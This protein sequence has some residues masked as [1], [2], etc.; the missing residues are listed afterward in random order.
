MVQVIDSADAGKEISYASTP[1]SEDQGYEA[2]S[3]TKEDIFQNP[4]D[5]PNTDDANKI[6]DEECTHCEIT[7]VK[8][9]EKMESTLETVWQETA[10]E[11]TDATKLRDDVGR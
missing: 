6:T 4:A 8:M 1:A 11:T 3:G 9:E 10:D 2:P 7:A 5:H